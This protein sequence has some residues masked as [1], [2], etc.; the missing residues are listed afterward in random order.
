M[1]NLLTAVRHMKGDDIK[2]TWTWAV[3]SLLCKSLFLISKS[4]AQR[5]STPEN[6]FHLPLQ[7]VALCGNF[8]WGRI[9][10]EEIF[11]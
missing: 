3:L 1:S 10:L 7:S 4:N 6:L 11:K 8:E 9:E 2:L 5:L